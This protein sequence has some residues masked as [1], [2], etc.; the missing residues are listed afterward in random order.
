MIQGKKCYLTSVASDSNEQLRT[1]RNNPE[2]RKYFREHREITQ[3]MQANWYKN[4]VHNS[5]NSQYDF[6]IHDQDTGTHIGH[7]G[8]YYI[9][10]IARKAEFSIY[11]GDMDYRGKGIGSD[12]LKT[13]IKYGFEELN[14]NKIWCEV[15]SNNKAINI[16][17]KI[18]FVDEGILRQ[19][20]VKNGKYVDSYVLSMLKSEW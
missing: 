18:G 19:N 15:Y 4:R 20:A 17:R 11:I 13:L 2:I 7:C 9:D 8:L 14:L 3:Q 12:A 1:W 5:D 10:W 16:Y 6:E